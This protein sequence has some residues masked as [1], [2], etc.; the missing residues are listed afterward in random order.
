MRQDS[1]TLLLLL[2]G[3]TAIKGTVSMRQAEQAYAVAE[4][5]PAPT[6]KSAIYAWTMAESFM[7]KAREEYAHADYEA[8]EKFAAQAQDWVARA[9]ALAEQDPTPAKDQP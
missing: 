2:S 8:A 4:R 7:V 3:C 5:S 1:W 6:A 9:Q